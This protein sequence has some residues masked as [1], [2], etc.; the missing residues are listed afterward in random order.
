MREGGRDNT[1]HQMIIT[2]KC[3][4]CPSPIMII[5]LLDSCC[6]FLAEL[7]PITQFHKAARSLHFLLIW[8]LLTT[9]HWNWNE[10]QTLVMAYKAI[11]IW[12][13][14]VCL[15]WTLLLSASLTILLTHQSQLS[16]VSHQSLSLSAVCTCYSFTLEWSSVKYFFLT[17]VPRLDF[18]SKIGEEKDNEE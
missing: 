16:G 18:R 6:S 1:E 10:M 7:S 17:P 8:N 14:P 13:W 9:F 15:S 11:Y 12:F 2:S 3:Q 5:S 4:D